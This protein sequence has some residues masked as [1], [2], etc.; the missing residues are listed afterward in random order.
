MSTQRFPLGLLVLEAGRPG[1]LF[2]LS[3][4]QAPECAVTLG[5]PAF[6]VEGRQRSGWRFTER[7]LERSLVRGGK[8]LTLY[9]DDPASPALELAL[10]VRT[11]PHSPVLRFRY[12][13][14][15]PDPARL[16]KAEG[17]DRIR[18]FSVSGW[19]AGELSLADIQL[20]HFDPVPHSYMPCRVDYRPGELYEGQ[21]LAGPIEILHDEQASLLVAY[22]HGADHPHSFFDFFPHP[23][24]G[25]LELWARRGN[26]HHGQAL[27]FTSVWFE[28]GLAG[29]LV[30]NLLEHYRRFFLEDLAE[31]AASREPLLFYNTWNYQ[32]RQRYFRGRPY[33]ESM[34]LER[35]LAEIDVAHRIG[36]DVFVI[37]TGWYSKTGDWAVDPGRFPDGL[38]QVRRRLQEYG[39]RL[40]LWFNPTVAARTSRIYR[41]H[42][43]FAMTREGQPPRWH[44]V[45]ETEESTSMCLASGYADA[46]IETLVRLHDEL[47]VSYFKWD[48]IGQWGCDSPLHN[49]GGPQNSPEERAACYAYE[50]GRAMIR[51]AE[52]VGKRCPGSIV[53]FDVTEGGR[54]VGLGF[55]AAGKY[56][57]VNNGPYFSS[58]DIPQSVRIEPDTINALFYPGPARPRVCRTGARYDSIIPSVL[59]MTHHLTDGPALSQLNSLAAL[60]LGANGLW[61]DL[62]AL[63]EE[64]IDLLAAHLGDY[65]R[66]RQAAT[67]AY[68]RVMG[69]AGSSPEIHEKVDPQTASG[70]VAF[71]TVTPGEITY[72][73]R[74]LAPG[75]LQ[76][77][78]G[79][80][81]WELLPDGRVKIVVNL[82]RDGARVV[83]LFGV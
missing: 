17:R 18:Y 75:K 9:Y 38:Q 13:L 14:H 27:P 77:V 73:T 67:R 22:E 69:F 35:M 26:Y 2:A 1:E 34:N 41:E 3:L 46:F 83:Y 45:W 82:E 24:Q 33:L 78:K 68:P 65:K 16:T 53:D 7:A 47:G 20:S 61:G 74:P 70:L 25:T 40:G 5:G 39:M 37:D 54:F 60:M 50:M 44:E 80:D 48:G 10:T 52:E 31:N 11:Y 55:L 62:L 58:L 19:P 51:I 66:V 43:E 28:L 42:P 23:A 4:A 32:E 29:G 49:H 57:L 36:I 15:S 59:F 12:E 76:E 63:S 21:R 8:E 71:F 6:E 72:V 56:Y 79:A 30:E 64:D 81:S